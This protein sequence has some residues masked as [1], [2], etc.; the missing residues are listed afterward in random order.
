MTQYNKIT[1]LYSRLSVGDED[2]DGGESNSI[3]N[4]DGICQRY[5]H[6]KSE[7]TPISIVLQNIL[8][9]VVLSAQFGAVYICKWC[10]CHS[11]LL[12]NGFQNDTNVTINADRT[13]S[14]LLRA[15]CLPK[16]D[17]SVYGF[18][19]CGSHPPEWIFDDYRRIVAYSQLQEQDS[20]ILVAA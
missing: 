9:Q 2:R 20:Q 10:L 13:R 4:Q 16:I 7:N 6:P 18:L 17:T 1:A 14:N 5:F 3:V 19:I 8:P 11:H 15:N 12:Q